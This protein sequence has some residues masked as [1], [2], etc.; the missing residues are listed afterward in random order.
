MNNSVLIN[1]LR[2]KNMQNTQNLSNNKQEQNGNNK[3]N[4][5]IEQNYNY[6]ENKRKNDI[7]TY[8]TNMWKPIIGSVNKDKIFENDL[9]IQIDKPNVEIIKSTYEKEIENRLREKEL[10]DKLAKEYAIANN[11]NNSVM[12]EITKP[13]EIKQ[14]HLNNLSNIDNTFIELKTYSQDLLKDTSNLN[15]DD[16]MNSVSKLD[17]LLNSVKNL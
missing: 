6:V 1:S 4:P 5:D 9:K 14:E 3:Y 10:A 7:Y 12:E 15:I 16:I 17:D 11:L 2:L 13:I 8:S